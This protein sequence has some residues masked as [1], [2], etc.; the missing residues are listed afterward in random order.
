V[1]PSPLRQQPPIAVE[2]RVELDQLICSIQH[3]RHTYFMAQLQDIV[4]AYTTETKQIRLN[5]R[6]EMYYFNQQ[7]AEMEPFIELFAFEVACRLKPKILALTS[8]E[9]LNVNLTSAFLQC[10]FRF[11]NTLEDKINSGYYIRNKTG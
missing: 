1:R 4:M 5:T 9:N 11:V 10:C 7:I 8:S 2:K 3:D 6:L